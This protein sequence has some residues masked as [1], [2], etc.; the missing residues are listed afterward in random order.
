MPD[1]NSEPAKVNNDAIRRQQR[2]QTFL[3]LN[4]AFLALVGATT[5]I[6]MVAHRIREEFVACEA[7]T[8]ACERDLRDA[9]AIMNEQKQAKK[10]PRF[11]ER[12]IHIFDNPI[13]MSR[14]LET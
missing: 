11:P 3:N 8:A 13:T 10:P 7:K 1:I 6:I 4:M 5:I 2:N 9:Y 14:V 12:N